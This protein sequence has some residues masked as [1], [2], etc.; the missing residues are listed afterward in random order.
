MILQIIRKIE[1]LKAR[2]IKRKK[3]KSIHEKRKS[4]LMS[5]AIFALNYIT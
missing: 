3:Y 1:K 2:I 5:F 4:S